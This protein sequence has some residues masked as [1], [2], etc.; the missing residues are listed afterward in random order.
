MLH[1]R[2]KMT[3]G[4]FQFFI[5]GTFA[6]AFIFMSMLEYKYKNEALA[7]KKENSFLQEKITTL[8]KGICIKQTDES[9]KQ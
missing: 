3:K 4:E 2:L 5:T 1:E 8:K 9:L 6:F 7:L